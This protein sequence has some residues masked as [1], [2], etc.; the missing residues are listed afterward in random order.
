MWPGVFVGAMEW[1]GVVRWGQKWLSVVKVESKKTEITNKTPPL[2]PPPPS[3][4]KTTT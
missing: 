2:F 3:T 4:P 1:L